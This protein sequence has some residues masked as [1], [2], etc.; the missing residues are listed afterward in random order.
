MRLSVE[1]ADVERISG[2]LLPGKGDKVVA[3]EPCIA[4]CPTP[5]AQA[6]P[7]GSLVAPEKLPMSAAH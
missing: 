2:R 5:V 3:R 6:W 1:G 7:T 4:N